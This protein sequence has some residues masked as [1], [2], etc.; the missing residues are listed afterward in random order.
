MKTTAPSEI[1]DAAP[2][3]EKLSLFRKEEAES[4]QVNLLLVNLDL[5]EVG[6]VGKISGQILGYAVLDVDANISI[7]DI[8]CRRI[9]FEI[10]T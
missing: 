5:R 10:S 7:T 1:E 8:P 4:S 6:V 2:L 9:G 3:Q